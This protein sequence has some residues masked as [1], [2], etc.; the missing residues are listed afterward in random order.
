[1]GFCAAQYLDHSLLYCQPPI[2]HPAASPIRA[3]AVCSSAVKAA[4]DMDAL[5]IVI[6]TNT[7]FPIRAVSKYRPR[8][9][10]VV[11]TTV[12]HV[13]RQVSPV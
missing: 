3:Q 11:V 1:M 13:A 12:P 6:A 8:C 10:V 4:I 2:L 9:A 7:C 5:F